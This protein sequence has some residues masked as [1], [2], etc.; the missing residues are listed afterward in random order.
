[1]AKVMSSYENIGS[2]LLDKTA[3]LLTALEPALQFFGEPEVG[4]DTGSF[5]QV[6]LRARNGNIG[7]RTIENL[8]KVA[9]DNHGELEIRT[10]GPVLVVRITKP[11]G[12]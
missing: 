5:Y 2:V 6:V 7:H 1:M 3:K 12:P 8:I 4:L 10:D 11:T 9:K